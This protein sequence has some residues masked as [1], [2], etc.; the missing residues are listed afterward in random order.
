M[1]QAKVLC[2][3]VAAACA[4][5]A[6]TSAGASALPPEFG[7]CVKTVKGYMGFGYSDAGCTNGVASDAKYEWLPGPGLDP[8]FT[9]TARYRPGPITKLCLSGERYAGKATEYGALAE[10][11]ETAAKEAPEPLKK[12]L[13]EKAK[14]YREQQKVAEEKS[15]KKY[16]ETKL[17]N[18]VVECPILIEAES[19]SAEPVVLETVSGL[20]VE[21]EK[22]SGSG[23]YTGTK[24]V[25]NV[26]T[27][28]TGCEVSETAIKCTSPGA[29]EG[30]IIP[31][32]LHG[33]LG[34]IKEEGNPVNNR[35]GLDDR[36]IRLRWAESEGDR[37]GH[38]RTRDQQDARE[39]NRKN[40]PE[41]RLSA[42]RKTR[43]AAS[44]RSLGADRR[45]S[46]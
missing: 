45:I 23:E 32:T 34:L 8:H 30:E 28:F 42:A 27:T 24:T 7:R 33:E 46:S 38:P 43:R 21:C 6:M 17:P 37:L 40:D 29:K 36:R 11:Y 19:E 25:G 35:V 13:E 22:L 20:A 39:R 26:N 2:V 16:E 4:I 3:A 1:R 44:R 31:A 15:K 12:E 5:G 14:K 10:K 41:E 9:T 18:P